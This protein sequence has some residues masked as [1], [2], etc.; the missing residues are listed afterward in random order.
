MLGVDLVPLAEQL[1]AQYGYLAVF[2]F[3]FLESSMLFPLLPSEAVLPL[4]AALLVTGVPSLA[5]FALAATAG[6]VVG[7]V[8]AYYLFGRGGEELA[9]RYSPFLSVSER[10]LEWT[11]RAFDRYGESS[12]FWGRFLPV[13]RSVVSVPAGFA[14]MDVRRFAAYSAGGGLLFNLAVGALALGG[15]ESRSVYGTAYALVR[16]IVTTWPVLAAA[17]VAVLLV[18]TAVAWWRFSD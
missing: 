16:Q 18:G 1:L 5:A 10:E 4:S 17:V 14:G 12:V 2:C 13:L 9:D 11:K 15:G 7:S 6:V 3:T 8:V